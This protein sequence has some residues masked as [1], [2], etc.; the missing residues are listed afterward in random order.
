MINEKILKRIVDEITKHHTKKDT[1]R[2]NQYQ[3]QFS[4]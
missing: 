1:P 2:G 3:E 4:L